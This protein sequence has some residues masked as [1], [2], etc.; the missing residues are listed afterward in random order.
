M[1]GFINILKPPGMSSAAVVSFVKRITKEKRVGHAGTL[2]PEAAGVLPVM[3][4]RATRLFDFLVEKQKVYVA[5]AAFGCSTDTMDAQGT[6]LATGDDY[7]S[8]E[9]ILV[10]LQ[11]LTGDIRQKPSMYSAIKKDG[12]PMYMRARAGE[13]VDVPERVVHV[14]RIE[15]LGMKPGHGFL[16]RITCGRGTYIRSICDDLGR[17]CGCPCHMRFLERESTGP[18]LLDT[19]V[20]LEEAEAAMQEG[21]TDSVLLPLD[22]PL[23]HLRRL[24][25]PERL[26]RLAE[27]G[28]KLPAKALGA[29][30]TEDEACRAYLSDRFAGIAA[31]QGDVLAWKLL[32]PREA[33]EQAETEK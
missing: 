33:D 15:P 27:N 32:I 7:P 29:D 11:K 23:A 8:E 19:A 5:E 17:L 18:F 16:M 21:R 2:D 13:S 30:I 3:V 20:T 14:D 12:K 24:D 1:N 25:I 31:R 10:E 9:R 22:Y 26:A 6:V 4:G 28:G